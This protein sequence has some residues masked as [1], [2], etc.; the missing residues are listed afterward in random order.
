M[1]PIGQ[2][3]DVLDSPQLLGAPA[4]VD[5]TLRRLSGAGR[6]RGVAAR[7]H[8]KSLKCTGL[9]KH[10]AVAGASGFLAAKLCEAEA[11]VNA[12]LTDVYIANQ[13]VGPL[14]LARLAN[15]AQ[16]A[17]MRVCVDDPGN[18]E[19]MG[20]AASKAGSTIGVL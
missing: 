13:V 15:L 2:P 14:K 17:S 16:R 1:H 4:V 18:I 8:F 12:G 11:L 9:A 20:A 5:S 10:I 19:Q 6:E 7:V 3:V